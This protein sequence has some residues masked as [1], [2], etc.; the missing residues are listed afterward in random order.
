M[1]KKHW[2]RKGFTM[3][4]LLIVIAIIVVLAGVGFIAL[5]SHMRN[6]EKLELDGQAKEIFVAAQNHLALADSQ[7]YLGRTGFG[8]EENPDAKDDVYYY[9]IGTDHSVLDRKTD[10]LGLMLPFAAVD[11]ST[12]SGGS[13]SRS[14]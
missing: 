11:E 9:V 6:M 1:M 3:A 8:T 4:E 7:G 10:I 12:R 2:N 14:S 5:L 13:T